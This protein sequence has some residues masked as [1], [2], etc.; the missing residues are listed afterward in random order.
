M[1]ISVN[2]NPVNGIDVAKY[3]GAPAR[4]D[5]VPDWLWVLGI[6]ATDAGKPLDKFIDPQFL[7]NRQWARDVSIPFRVLYC[8]L[9]EPTVMDMSDQMAI[10]CQ[11]VGSLEEGECVMIDWERAGI[12]M[13]NIREVERIMNVVYP[14]RWCMYVNDVTPDMITW[15]NTR[16]V[17][18]VHP[19]W[20]NEGW[21]AAEKWDAM[22]WQVSIANDSNTGYWSDLKELYPKATAIDVDW[23]RKVDELERLCGGW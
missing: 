18:L 17:P 5:P 14:Y 23:V 16:Q 2:G 13:A 21:E 12:T 20:S 19:D 11:A 8:F 4:I 3:Q 22:I 6:K 7:A 1:I 10:F 15:M 9:R